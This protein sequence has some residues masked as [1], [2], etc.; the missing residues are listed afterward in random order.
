MVY[1]DKALFLDPLFCR[2]I[3]N[4][5]LPEVVCSDNTIALY[6]DDSKMFRVTDCTEDQFYFQ[7]DLD[8]LLNQMDFN[9]KKCKIMRIT[10]KKVPFT[11]RVHLNDTVLEEVM[12]FKD[13]GVLT[14]NS[15]T[16]NSHIDMISA[17]A[18]KMLG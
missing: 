15:L 10:R 2:V 12:E 6:A 8:N 18:N 3:F 1:P 17:K 11:N 14:Y 4:N 7:L 9:T 13:L 5:D 16:W